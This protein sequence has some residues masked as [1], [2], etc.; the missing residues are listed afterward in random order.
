MTLP[1][2][3]EPSGEIEIR[4][5]GVVAVIHR[6]DE[7]MLTIRRSQ[8]VAAPGKLCFPGGGLE[9]GE[10]EPTALKREL[11]E[12]LR[13]KIISGEYLWRTVT[14]WGVDLAFWSAKIIAGQEINPNPQEVESV[15]WLNLNE[16]AARADVL[17]SNREF[18][19]VL[20]ES[21]LGE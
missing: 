11:R 21:R 13:L 1:N 4:R 12:E 18:L 14:P 19:Q 7:R 2:S 15:L 17:E 10:D 8:F 5:Y 9:E 20:R 6:E 16:M 3:D